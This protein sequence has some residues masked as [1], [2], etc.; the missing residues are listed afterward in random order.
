MREEVW[1]SPSWEITRA[2]S[3]PLGQRHSTWKRRSLAV[4]HA[5]QPLAS[6]AARFSETLCRSRRLPSFLLRRRSSDFWILLESRRSS[7]WAEDWPISASAAQLG[8]LGRFSSARDWI[9]RA[10]FPT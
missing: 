5:T 7:R 8:T 6:G 3:L 10:R 9:S 1:G 4:L 2:A